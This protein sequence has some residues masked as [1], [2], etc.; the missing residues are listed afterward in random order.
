MK[1]GM[2]GF[3]AMTAAILLLTISGCGEKKSK[4]YICNGPYSKRYHKTENCKG[5]YN[6][7]SSIEETTIE[8]AKDRGRTPCDY[9]Y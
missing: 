9:C 5:L 1:R 2:T 8:K 3:L 4:V 6:C 7:S